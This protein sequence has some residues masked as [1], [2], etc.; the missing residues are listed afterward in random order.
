MHNL[1]SFPIPPSFPSLL[2][3]ELLAYAANPSAL[4]SREQ[5]F[6]SVMIQRFRRE[7]DDRLEV[8]RRE[9]GVVAGFGQGA[10]VQRMQGS[11]L[12]EGRGEEREPQRRIKRMV[13]H[14]GQL[15]ADLGRIRS[16]LAKGDLAA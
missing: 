2:I 15:A 9:K 8:Q 6:S 11:G 10:T 1:D 4:A 13:S 14:S 12:R 7:R 3:F 5:P 16:D